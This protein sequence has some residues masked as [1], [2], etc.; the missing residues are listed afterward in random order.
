[1]SESEIG[2]CHFCGD[3]C[4]KSSQS[5]GR[6]MRTLTGFSLGWNILPAHLQYVYPQFY[7]NAEKKIIVENKD[8][9]RPFCDSKRNLKHDK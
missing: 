1:M 8:E 3:H 6:C 5:C 7:P 2:I 4:N 9:T